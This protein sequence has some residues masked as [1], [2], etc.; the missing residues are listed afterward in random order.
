[1]PLTRIKSVRLRLVASVALIVLPI[2]SLSVILASTTY[3]SLIEGIEASQIQITSHYGVRTQ[4]WYRGAARALLSTAASIDSFTGADAD[5]NASLRS[6]I[7]AN[8]GYKAMRVRFG[9]GR[10]C[11]ASVDDKFSAE[12]LNA[13]AQDQAA[14]AHTQRWPGTRDGMARFDVIRVGGALYLLVDILNI[15]A[16]GEEWRA[17]VL[18]DPFLLASALQLDPMDSGVAFAVMKR[19]GE[20]IV[21]RGASMTDLSWLP[22]QEKLSSGVT[23]WRGPSLAG[24]ISSYGARMITEPDLY[25]LAR[26]DDH[27]SRAAWEQFLI[28]CVTPLLTILLL[29]YAY[30]RIVQKDVIR[31]VKAIE[32]SAR[33]QMLNPGRALPAPVDPK[34]P[35]ELK[36][37]SEALNAMMGDANKRENALRKLLEVNRDLMRELHHRVKNSL[38]VIQSYLALSRREHENEDNCR[39]AETEAR[40]QVLATAYRLALTEGGMRLVPI[41]PFTEEIVDNISSFARAP[42]QWL[43]L[44][45][46]WDGALVIDRIIPLGLALV[47]ILIA[48]L[49]AKDATNVKVTLRAFDGDQIELC[50]AVD[51]AV[52]NR[53]SEKVMAGLAAQL[54]A[55]R[56][57]GDDGRVFIW[58]FTP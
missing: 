23:L 36:S 34:M 14:R 9:G 20:L 32:A 47:E 44:S 31:W 13:I 53:P 57:L 46:E 10:L 35:S 54:G 41:K 18:A 55:Q 38:Q 28:L 8:D 26:F 49:N 50:V 15:D 58:R 5:C 40:V 21:A 56:E 17:F 52:E 33:S 4:A 48:G 30:E 11:E 42:D 43:S 6:V 7:A 19:G 2:A 37:V 22:A 29:F 16:S 25:V 24:H 51:V 45:L 1:M 12:Q 39:L 3:R 27:A